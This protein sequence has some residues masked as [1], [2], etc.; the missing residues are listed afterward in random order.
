MPQLQPDPIQNDQKIYDEAFRELTSQGD[1]LDIA[2]NQ[3]YRNYER[4][5]QR[6]G[7][8]CTLERSGG[9]Y[10]K[11]VIYGKDDMYIEVEPIRENGNVRPLM[12]WNEYDGVMRELTEREGLGIHGKY[13]YQARFTLKS[14]DWDPQ[15]AADFDLTEDDF[16]G[17]CTIATVEYEGWDF[18][19]FFQDVQY[20]LSEQ[21]H[22]RFYPQM[23]RNLTGF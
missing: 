1:I 7:I 17:E 9:H 2:K 12:R 11:G 20:I 8:K 21:H 14:N 18:Q 13:V 19:E 4:N 16:N 3:F 10:T 5:F 23:S 15:K 22:V 6:M